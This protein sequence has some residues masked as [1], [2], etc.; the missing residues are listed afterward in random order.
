MTLI[1]QNGWME[2]VENAV[3]EHIWR[4]E[5]VRWLIQ[6]VKDSVVKKDVSDAIK[7]IPYWMEIV[8]SKECPLML[9]QTHIV[10]GGIGMENA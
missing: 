9:I 10:Q 8:L 4:M 7:D 3:I 6:I 2:S 5:N 1:A